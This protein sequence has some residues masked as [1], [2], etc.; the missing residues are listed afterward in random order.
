M[1][2]SLEARAHFE[3]CGIDVLTLP[4][5]STDKTQGLDRVIFHPLKDVYSKSIEADIRNRRSV[6]RENFP[7]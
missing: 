1:H 4:P 5:H 2:I 6:C 3:L 7:Q